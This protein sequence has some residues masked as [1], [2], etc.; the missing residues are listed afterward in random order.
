MIHEHV[1]IAH[2]A[3]DE[4]LA[5]EAVEDLEMAIAAQVSEPDGA[6]QPIWARVVTVPMDNS[7]WLALSHDDIR[8]LLAALDRQRMTWNGPISTWPGWE[9]WKRLGTSHQQLTERSHT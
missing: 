9:I 1:I 5:A 7:T 3:T 8:T 4:P 2:F 6:Y